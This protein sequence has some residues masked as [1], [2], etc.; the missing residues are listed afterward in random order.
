MSKKI[1]SFSVIMIQL[2]TQFRGIITVD[3]LLESEYH[4]TS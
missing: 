2:L 3:I 1:Q 4:W